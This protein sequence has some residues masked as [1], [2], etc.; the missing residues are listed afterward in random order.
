[1]EIIEVAK[2]L[3][4]KTG[5][6]R[7]RG[8]VKRKREIADKV[9]IV[10]RDASGE[11]QGVVEKAKVKPADFEAAM[12]IYNE[13]SLYLEG[14]LKK[15]VRAPNGV[16]LKVTKVEPIWIGEPFPIQKDLSE[17]FLRDVRHLWIRSTKLS[18]AMRMKASVL[19]FFREFHEKEGYTEI[20]N[21]SFVSGAVE[22]GST[23][24]EVPYFDKKVYL[25]QS[26]QFYNEA[27]I[28]AFEKIYTASP[29]YRA[30][31][32]RTRRHLTEFL[33]AEME[34]AWMQLPDLTKFCENMISH[35]VKRCLEEHSEDL[36][37]L[38]RNPKELKAVK[39][40]FDRYKY[41]EVLEVAKKKFPE[42]KF[43]SDLGEAEERE[44]TK[45]FKKPII[46]THYPAMLKP[47]YHRPDPDDQS[48]V[49]CMDMLAPEGYGE[50]IGGGERCW[51]VDE[52]LGRMKAER[53]DPVPYQWYVDLRKYGSVPHAGFGLGIERL[54]TWICKLPHIF[55]VI[56]FPRTMDRI[57]P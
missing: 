4:K 25:T 36:E 52:L 5:K 40:P 9:F 11:I 50:I 16:E 54:T 32:S 56:G 35:I 24:F 8:W 45:D 37:F 10:L 1:M 13:S 34:A 31:K 29:S 15:D 20:F 12:K 28:F 43:G 42:L 17:E 51:Q 26:G 49:L 27:Y 55:D 3:K 23:L 47:F 53:I 30:E 38:G 41:R 21:P 33:H 22:G 2:A 18:K 6:V 48:V 39:P 19:K 14:S 7:M 57:H 44:I 46:V